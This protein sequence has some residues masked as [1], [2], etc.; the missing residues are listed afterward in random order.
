MRLMVASDPGRPVQSPA[1]NRDLLVPGQI[2]SGPACVVEYASTT[3][4][5][6]GDR[7][8]V[9]GTGELMIHIAEAQR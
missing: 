8:E 6:E 9:L 3:I 2:I 1:Y 5:F 7:L 4:L